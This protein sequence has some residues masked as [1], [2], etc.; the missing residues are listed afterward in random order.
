M[1]DLNDHYFQLSETEDLFSPTIEQPCVVQYKGIWY[2]A[3]V[4]NLS[5]NGM[6]VHFVD[7]GNSAT[8]IEPSAV[9]QMT[10]PF[11]K[12]PQVAVEC[13]LDLNQDEWSEETTAL[14]EKLTGKNQLVIK[15]VSQQGDRCEV[16]VFDKDAHC[17]I[18][19]V[20]NAIAGAGIV[21]CQRIAKNLIN[22]IIS[23]GLI[24]VQKAFSLGLFL[25]ELICGGAWH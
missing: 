23:P 8:N 5:V 18:G 12:I 1:N 11:L 24:F 20:I 25:R 4:L 6:T 17:I 13:S 22:P 9:K 7:Y 21:L 2:R 3:K 15:T 14:F 16:K 19:Q 10:L